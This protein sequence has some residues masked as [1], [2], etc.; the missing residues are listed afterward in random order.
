MEDKLTTS[1]QRRKREIA[2]LEQRVGDLLKELSFFQ[3]AIWEA[4]EATGE[5]LGVSPF[6]DLESHEELL[7]MGLDKD[8]LLE[9]I[10]GLPLPSDY[11]T[12]GIRGDEFLTPENCPEM[13][14]IVKI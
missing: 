5:M 3:K 4:R 10:R 14:G 13:S 11:P 1:Y 8:E 12:P 7:T 9:I 6:C 2:Y